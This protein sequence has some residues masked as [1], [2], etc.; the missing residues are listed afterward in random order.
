M[1]AAANDWRYKFNLITAEETEEW[2][3]CRELSLNDLNDFLCREILK[4][5]F[6]DQLP[7]IRKQVEIDAQ[8]VLE[9]FWPQLVLSNDYPQLVIPLIWRLIVKE[10]NFSPKVAI[11]DELALAKN[12]YCQRQQINIDDL[13][14]YL[15]NSRLLHDSF[16]YYLTLEAYYR[17]FCAQLLSDE[18]AGLLLKSMFKQLIRIVYES[19]YFSELEHAKEAYLC[20]TEDGAS[21]DDIAVKAGGR[22]AKSVQF[23]DEIP[24]ELRQDLLSA[25]VGEAIPPRAKNGRDGFSLHRV[26]RKVEPELENPDVY[27]R[28]LQEYVKENLGPLAQANVKW[29][30]WDLNLSHE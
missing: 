2:F 20:V 14:S 18:M 21:L 12:E 30:K 15:K 23:L 28:V 11:V 3:G 6:F 25:A 9:N 5:H 4:S 27:N 19:V 29:L 17:R 13:P 22:Y 26:L 1:Q 8:S 7:E 10:F 24:E 16:N